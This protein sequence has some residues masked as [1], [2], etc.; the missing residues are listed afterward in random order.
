MSPRDLY[1]RLINSNYK[2]ILV[3]NMFLFLLAF[4]HI[5]Y[6]YISYGKVFDLSVEIMGG[7]LIALPQKIDLATLESILVNINVSDYNLYQ[8]SKKIYI[9]AKNLNKDL[10]IKELENYGIMENEITVQQFSSYIG[11][12]IFSQLVTLL[13]I[14]III[15]SFMI[16]IRFRDKRPVLGIISVILWDF[17]SVIALINLLGIKVGPIGIV[18]LMGILGFA[19][20]NNVV[21][22]TNV[23]QEKEK[24]FE[25]RIRMSLKI[26]LLMELFIILVA[27]PLYLLIDLPTIK[28]FSLILLLIALMD[29]YAYLFINIPLYKYFETKYQQ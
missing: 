23:F 28:E 10:I 22:A 15:I 9:E 17:L 13:V 19:I 27:I 25:D 4:G 18:T 6:N 3:I 20:D 11:G 14:S 24:S 16:L 21:L 1:M 29:I 7:Y 8:T 2:K 26:G 5:L 12:I